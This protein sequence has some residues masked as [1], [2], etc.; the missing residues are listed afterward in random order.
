MSFTPW[1]DV[2]DFVIENGHFEIVKY[3]HSIGVSG[4]KYGLEGG[5]KNGHFEIIKFLFEKNQR[6][7]NVRALENAIEYGHFELVKYFYHIKWSNNFDR[8]VL[9]RAKQNGHFK[10]LQYIMNELI[11][12]F[13]EFLE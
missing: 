2:M 4:S 10:I 7:S 8:Y 13:K 9:S 11:T 6:I 3:F 5:C 1:T 12:E